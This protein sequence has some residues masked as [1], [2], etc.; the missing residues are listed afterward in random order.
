MFR[1]I[2]FLN[3][4]FNF[5]VLSAQI[6][7]ESYTIND[8][9]SSN[10]IRCLY[11][12]FRGFLWI[13]TKDGLNRFDGSEF[14][15][16]RQKKSDLNSLCNN[17]IN[18]IQHYDNQ[19]LIICTS[20]GIDFYDTQTDSFTHESYFNRKIILTLLPDTGKWYWIGTFN[21]LYYYNFEKKKGIDFSSQEFD[22]LKLKGKT[23]M[24]F[25]KDARGR[26]WAG[27]ELG[28]NILDI[29]RSK[30]Y[31]IN[32]QT[33]KGLSSN[34][35]QVVKSD[36]YGNVWVGTSQ[37][38]L[39]Y[40]T[41]L[42]SLKDIPQFV[43]FSDGSVMDILFDS[44]NKI[45]IGNGSGKG[46][47]YKYHPSS[48][49]DRE[50]RF[51]AKQFD[52]FSLTDN[53]I[54][55]LYEDKDKNIFIGTY[56]GGLVYYSPYFKKF[57]SIVFPSITGKLSNNIVNAFVEDDKYFWIGTESGLNRIEKK[58][59]KLKIFNTNNSN[60]GGNAIYVLYIDSK[61]RLW[62]GAWAGGLNL[63]DYKKEKFISFLHKEDDPGS[64]PSNNVFAIAE[65]TNNQIWVGTIRGGLS[66]WDENKKK[67]INYTYQ[68][69]PEKA[70]FSSSINQ[71]VP[72]S[73]GKLWLSTFFSAALF[74]PIK[75]SFENY[76]N[77]KDPGSDLLCIFIDS[78]GNI[79][80]GSESNLSVLTN[81]KKLIYFDN[82]SLKNI[83]AILE[84][85]KCNLWLSSN[86]GLIK[87]ESAVCTPDTLKLIFYNKI[88]RRLNF[89]S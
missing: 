4:Y 85:E 84:D 44:D 32:N 27:T 60:I 43:H 15:I 28:L 31:F 53:S 79:W 65:D 62:V 25:Y 3:L 34:F 50:K 69:H 39:E 64:L 48:G 52:I 10:N 66:K 89:F 77:I 73:D 55:C 86:R 83:K 6:R 13:G 16:Y 68:T 2:I 58:T 81:K 21:G 38:G 45:W 41:L 24:A 67:F 78:K 51:I 1:F 74:D 17:T 22:D 82:D 30:N 18:V 7:F 26:L 57:Q 76:E 20:G 9:L 87:F 70:L 37:G 8:G 19:K 14:I 12:D 47:Q 42:E 80:F 54:E 29:K 35:V 59:G 61:K 88:R 63:Y 5:Y 40:C 23:F 36:P 46:I 56:A 75:E 49:I 11:R 33:P 72:T 71:I